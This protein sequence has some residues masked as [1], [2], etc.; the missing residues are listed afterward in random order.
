MVYTVGFQHDGVSIGLDWKNRQIVPERTCRKASPTN[1]PQC[2]QA[3]IDWLQAE[4]AWYASKG[5]LNSKQ[6][7]MQTAVCE[8]ARAL[9]SY[10]SAQQLADR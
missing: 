7:G 4:C 2:R 9:S 10:V 3:A 8:G 1:R 6:A 5:K